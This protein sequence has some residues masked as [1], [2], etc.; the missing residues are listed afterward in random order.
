[1]EAAQISKSP[2]KKPRLQ[3]AVR[4]QYRPLAAAK[5]AKPADATYREVKPAIT[6]NPR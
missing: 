6:A 4:R 3:P 1:V 2:V 5:I